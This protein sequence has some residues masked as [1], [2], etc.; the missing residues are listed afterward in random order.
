MRRLMQWISDFLR[1]C[2]EG[3]YGLDG[4]SAL[5]LIISVSLGISAV[6]MPPGKMRILTGLG[7]LTLAVYGLHRC[8]SRDTHRQ[9]R[10]WDSV[11]RE[12]GEL[13]YKIALHTGV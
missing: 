1:A 7:V 9:R 8:F 2:M 11:E 3:R 13:D 6:N 12:L 10:Q 4:L 5:Y